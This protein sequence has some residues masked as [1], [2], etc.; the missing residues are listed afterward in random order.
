MNS[1]HQAHDRSLPWKFHCRTTLYPRHH[2]Q[3]PYK[4]TQH[5]HTP[6]LLLAS[7][8]LTFFHPNLPRHLCDTYVSVLLRVLFTV[9]AIATV[10]L[11]VLA[12]IGIVTVQL[13]VYLHVFTFAVY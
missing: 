10:Q 1:I 2:Q 12:V 11:P 5:L 6:Y 7:R 9:T 13:P 3:R 4:H 8:L